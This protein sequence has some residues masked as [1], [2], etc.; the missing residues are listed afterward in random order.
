MNR[1]HSGG[2]SET[3]QAVVRALSILEALAEVAE[4]IA[5]SDLAKKVG[6]KL[7]TVHRLLATLMSKG[8][9]T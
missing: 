6:L 2:G 7:A 4:P 5:L 9:V 1:A 8:Y 3:V